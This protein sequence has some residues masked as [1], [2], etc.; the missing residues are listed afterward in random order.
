MEMERDE[1]AQLLKSWRKREGLSVV[2]AGA[3][4]DLSKRTIEGIE[5]GRGFGHAQIMKLALKALID[6]KN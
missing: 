4:L 1:L 5:Q 6:G 2:E 3:I